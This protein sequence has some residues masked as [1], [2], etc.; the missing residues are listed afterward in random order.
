MAKL[1]E[2]REPILVWTLNSWGVLLP[3]EVP[4]PI[5]Q[6]LNKKGSCQRRGFSF[7]SRDLVSFL[8]PVSPGVPDSSGNLRIA[9][10]EPFH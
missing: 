6:S 5:P 2:V 1:V 10:S 8:L 4:N 7:S 3:H 9:N